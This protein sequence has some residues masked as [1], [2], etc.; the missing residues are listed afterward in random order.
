MKF[1]I[2]SLLNFIG[3]IIQS[4]TNNRDRCDTIEKSWSFPFVMLLLN[5]VYY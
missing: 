4:K 5:N 1:K 3:W 2:Q